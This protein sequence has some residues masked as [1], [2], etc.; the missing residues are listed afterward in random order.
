MTADPSEADLPAPTIEFALSN[1]HVRP[2]VTNYEDWRLH[3][4]VDGT[5]WFLGVFEPLGVEDVLW[6]YTTHRWTVTVDN[7]LLGTLDERLAPSAS[8][9]FTLAG[10]GPGTYAFSAVGAFRGSETSLAAVTPFEL[11]GERIEIVPSP[12]V[13]TTR[14]GETMLVSETDT[15][16]GQAYRIEARLVDEAGLAPRLVPAW[17]LRQE[18][19]RNTIPFLSE[20]IRTAVYTTVG[21]PV[22]EM[23]RIDGTTFRYDGRFVTF[24][25]GT[26]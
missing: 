1:R 13:E 16:S 20:R 8:P 17:G 11:G 9:S 15:S 22:Y 3:E 10:L 12:D 6:P 26:V 25:V 7:E 24:D 14:E 18:G 4:W 23:D 2:F 19:I 21:P 5:W